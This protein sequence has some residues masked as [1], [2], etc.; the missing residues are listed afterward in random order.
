MENE[1]MAE[2][3]TYMPEGGYGLPPYI[4]HCSLEYIPEQAAENGIYIGDPVGYHI[5][6]AYR[7]RHIWDVVEVDGVRIW[8]DT[9]RYDWKEV[10]A[11]AR[12]TERK[13]ELK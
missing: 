5:G 6:R 4:D 2:I 8:Y 13:G 12:A 9:H 1:R 10:V 7:Y 11:M 3:V